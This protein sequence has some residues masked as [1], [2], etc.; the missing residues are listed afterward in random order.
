VQKFLKN[1]PVIACPNKECDYERPAPEL[2]DGMN[3]AGTT[4]AGTTA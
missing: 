2:A 1:G 4:A 3:G